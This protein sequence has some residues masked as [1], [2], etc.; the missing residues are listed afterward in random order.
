MLKDINLQPD[1]EDVSYD[2]E[3]LF[4]SIPIEETIDFI[5]HQIYQEKLIKPICSKT[6]FKRLLDKLS[7]ECTFSANNKLIKQI[8]GCPMGGPISVVFA[9]IFM[10]K[11]EKEVVRPLKPIFYKRYVDDIYVRRKKNT[12]DILYDKLNSY[13]PN[14]KFSIEIHPSKFLDTHIEINENLVQTSVAAKS[15]KVPIQWNSAVPKSYKRNNIL[16]DLHRAK[17]ISDD[18]NTEIQRIRNKY[19]KAD[20]PIRF[21]ESVIR[22]FKNKDNEDLL[23]PPWL[24][25]EKLPSVL[26]RLPFSHK[27]EETIFKFIQNL[28][29]F[30]SNNCKFIIIWNTR[31]IKTLFPLKD[32]TEHKSCVIYEGTCSCGH[33]YIGE[34]IRN[35]N[36]RWDEH[37]PINGNSEPS[38]HL[39]SNINHSFVWKILTNAPK[40][41]FKRKILE[42]YLIMNKVP[43]LNNQIDIPSLNLFRHGVT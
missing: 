7:K 1:E 16:G 41:S 10:C 2:V 12:P 37:N 38:K 34:T 6:I 39:Q 43:Q 4:T 15:T 30:T 23:I 22:S 14:I 32:R 24:F 18:F 26:I 17:A 13:H 29:N 20:Y 11:L 42:G 21:I 19:L 3:S 36:V 40:V 25:E 27:T 35:V 31:K 28:E 8:D 33:S 5:I 9:N